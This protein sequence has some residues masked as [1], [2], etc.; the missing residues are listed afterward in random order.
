M[1]R[2]RMLCILGCL[3]ALIGCLGRSTNDPSVKLQWAEEHFAQRDEP[4]QAEELIIE[5]IQLYQKTGDR[6]GRA[7]AYRQ[8]GLLLRSNAVTKFEKHYKQKE[9]FI[10]KSIQYTNRYQKAIEFFKQSREIF[11]EHKKYDKLSNIDI[12]LAKTYAH[13]N[14]NLEA[15][16]S[17]GSSLA[18]Y[19][20]YKKE[21]PEMKEFHAEELADYEE[22]VGI[23]KKQLACPE[24]PAAEEKVDV[25]QEPS[26]EKRPIGSHSMGAPV[27][28]DA[29]QDE[30]K[31]VGSHSM[32]SPE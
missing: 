11:A 10:D 32:G 27:I 9:G 20:L 23:L 5:A 13:L 8:Y 21:N 6:L 31:P 14:R 7:E 19:K 24:T 16:E 28:P 25:Q 29:T 18:N 26:E 3:A 22:Y 2:V 15:C 12:S 1:Q 30:K 17:L 4:V